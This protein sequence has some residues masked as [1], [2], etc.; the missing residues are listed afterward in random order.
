MIQIVC[1]D[2]VAPSADSCGG[3]LGSRSPVAFV[4]VVVAFVAFVA[5]TLVSSC[6]DKP[7]SPPEASGKS[8]GM[9]QPALPPGLAA[10]TTGQLTVSKEE[11]G[12]WAGTE[13]SRLIFTNRG[14][15]CGMY[16]APEL[17][18]VN[19]DGVQV[20]HAYPRGDGDVVRLGRG[21]AASAGLSAINQDPPPCAEYVQGLVAAPNSSDTTI[22]P[23]FG[24]ATGVRVWACAFRIGPVVAG[25]NATN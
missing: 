13:A 18:L 19:K 16:G 20:A 7:T 4:V 6:S 5:V 15:E 9:S 11:L 22:V 17:G 24:H 1:P 12:N 25:V 3:R 8:S 21:Q 14:D 2:N 23:G 10:C